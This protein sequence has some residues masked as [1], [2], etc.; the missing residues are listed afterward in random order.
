VSRLDLG[1][2]LVLAAGH[3]GLAIAWLRRPRPPR[4]DGS[5]PPERAPSSDPA[6][7]DDRRAAVALGAILVVGLVLRVI[8]LGEG[9]WFDEV[10]TQVRY[11]VHPLGTILTTYD[12]QNQHMLYSVLARIGFVLFGETPAA[13]RWP[14][15]AF[16]VVSLWAV[17]RFARRVAGRLESL[18]A[19]ALL[20]VSYHHVWFSQNARGYTG[21]LL[22]TLLATGFLVD[23][24]RNRDGSRRALPFAYGASIALAMYTH[25]TAIVLPVSHVAVAAWAAFGPRAKGASRPAIV[26]LLWGFVL[27]GTL[28]LQLYAPVV[29]Q[30]A[31]VLLHPTL[32]G[33]AVEWKN[34]IWMITETVA[35]LAAGLPGGVLALLPVAAV[36]LVGLASHLRRD[37]EATAAM[38]LPLVAT[39]IAI[40]AL[41]HNLWPRFFFFGAGFA[42]LIGLRG[43]LVACNAVAGARGP[44]IAA[45]T[46]GLA[47]L[48]SLATV[49]SAWAP[50]QD[51]LGAEAFVDANAAD[52]DA[53]V[54]VDMAI[55]PFD[56]WRHR[57]WATVAD[58]AELAE[59]EAGH[60]RTWLVYS[61]PAS[62]EALQ[63]GVWE[64]VRS[65]YREAARFG[66][67]VRGGDIFVMVRE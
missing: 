60:E 14:A 27:A 49:P 66:G 63:P 36:G 24:L 45:A 15:V 59:V 40:L 58:A 56:E 41:G 52:R 53:I 50:K 28:S 32:A 19:A 42:V 4:S 21:L 1:L 3:A 7:L 12:D 62:L 5:P 67:T 33:V 26:P 13:L 34:P 8:G 29:D 44:A 20:A 31:G 61:F 64:R 6:W 22:W 39:A 57:D 17:A 35:G 23:L 18:L 47:V 37:P 54:M 48:A 43:L 65:E 30:V 46:G 38:I 11:V 2:F 25:L 55:L 51:Y 16:G 9:L 10:K